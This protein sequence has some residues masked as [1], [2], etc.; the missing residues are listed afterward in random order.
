MEPGLRE[1]F[2]DYQCGSKVDGGWSP[3]YSFRTVPRSPHWSPRFAVYG[4][5]G[6]ANAK[7]LTRLSAEVAANNF[8]AILH[9][10]DFAYNMDMVKWKLKFF[11]NLCWEMFSIA[12]VS[13]MTL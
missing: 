7:S 10:G 5:L 13:E 2:S 11:L 12:V 1:G 3:V 8:D 9:V 4:D 6:L